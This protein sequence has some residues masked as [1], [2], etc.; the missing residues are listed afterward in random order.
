MLADMAT[1]IA[2]VQALVYKAAAGGRPVPRPD[3]G[4]A[5]QDLHLGNGNQDHRCNCSA[6][7]DIRADG[8]AAAGAVAETRRAMA[9]LKR[10]RLR[11][12]ER[13]AG[14]M[15]RPLG[16]LTFRVGRRVRISFA[17]A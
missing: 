15:G 7:P 17:P 3:L 12:R 16:T 10:A 4:G 8:V 11:S 9:L 2:A 1:G 5:G 6:Q 14:P 13:C